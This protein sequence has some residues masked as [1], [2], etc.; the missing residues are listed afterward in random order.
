MFRIIAVCN[1]WE[2]HKLFIKIDG[3]VNW[4]EKV[5]LDFHILSKTYHGTLS[6]SLPYYLG[7]SVLIEEVPSDS[8]KSKG[9]KP[10]GK[11]QVTPVQEEKPQGTPVH[12][13]MDCESGQVF[14]VPIAE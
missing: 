12:V 10:K 13:F 14:T 1:L 8:S 9:K 5:N 6:D 3:N 7:T 4:E 11:P 2:S